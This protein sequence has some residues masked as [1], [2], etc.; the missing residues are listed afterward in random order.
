MDTLPINSFY[1]LPDELYRCI[2]EKLDLRDR[3]TVRLACKR[4]KRICDDIEQSDLM[5]CDGNATENNW[6][7][8]N[9]LIEQRDM[10]HNVD[11][12]Y[13]FRFPTWAR[14]KLKRLK[15]GDVDC[16]TFFLKKLEHQL[17]SLAQ[18]EFKSLRGQKVKLKLVLPSLRRLYIGSS[19]AT[20]VKLRFDC[21]NLEAIHYGPG[22]AQSIQITH[23]TSIRHLEIHDYISKELLFQMSNVQVVHSNYIIN[24]R[25]EVMNVLIKSLPKLRSLHCEIGC[26]NGTDR[27]PLLGEIA[28]LSVVVDYIMREKVPKFKLYAR[29]VRIREG[30]KFDDY[31]FNADL[32]TLHHGYSGQ[33]ASRFP[34]MTALMYPDLID[35]YGDRLPIAFFDLYPNLRTVY[36]YEKIDQ[37]AFLTF[38]SHCHKLTGL[39]LIETKLNQAFYQ[40]LSQWPISELEIIENEKNIRFDFLS[41]MRSLHLL[42]TNKII[43]PILVLNLLGSS[44]SVRFEFRLYDCAVTIAK[45]TKSRFNLSCKKANPKIDFS[46]KQISYKEL[47]RLVQDIA[48]NG[49]NRGVSESG[50][51]P[52]KRSSSDSSDRDSSDRDSSDRDS[53]VR[54]SWGR[55]SWDRG[56]RDSDLDSLRSPKKKI[57]SEPTR[58]ASFYNFPKSSLS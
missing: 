2:F 36:V 33:L 14:Y 11:L 49:L 32:L 12:G 57:R 58:W 7:I 16:N 28:K 27:A 56:P 37:S 34:Q 53:R 19:S 6:F 25:M 48:T 23:P 17:R 1:Q 29:G 38:L 9:D 44:C 54:D 10:L 40:E 26:S 46:E 8:S 18:L 30:E 15:F 51:A 45:L 42:K 35:L 22:A 5:I 31:K 21:E 39:T 52:S 47:A 43:R 41:K 20:E 55:N 4:F 50:A 3:A 13:S 24:L